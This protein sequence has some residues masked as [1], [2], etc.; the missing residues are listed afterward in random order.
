MSNLQNKVKIN[1][2]ERRDR[3]REGKRMRNE[4]R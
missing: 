2:K 1:G 4:R 3:G